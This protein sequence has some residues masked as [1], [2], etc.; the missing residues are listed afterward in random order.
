MSLR[1]LIGVSVILFAG[2]LALLSLQWRLGLVQKSPQTTS[3]S[4]GG[5][6]F[7]GGGRA[8]VEFG[9]RRDDQAGLWVRCAGE[10]RRVVLRPGELSDEVCAVR[11][12]L[13]ELSSDSGTLATSR[14]HLEVS[15]E[16]DEEE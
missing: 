12:R 7:V 4:L 15:W 10:E 13:L 11:I 2:L 8:G 1:L 9:D 14:A 5:R 3:V 6:A 16:P